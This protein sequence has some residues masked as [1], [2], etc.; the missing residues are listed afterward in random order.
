MTKIS[1][2]LI[3]GLG[4]PLPNTPIQIVSTGTNSAIVGSTA[5]TK[6]GLDG[7]YSF[8]V[9]VGS[10][11]VSIAFGSL[12][13]QY[14]GS[15]EISSGTPDASLDDILVIPASMQPAVLTKVL[16]ALVDAQNAAAEAAAEVMA[17]FANNPGLVS[18]ATLSTLQSVHPQSPNVLGVV[19]STGLYYQWDGS[20]WSLAGYQPSEAIVSAV[21][22]MSSSLSASISAAL[23]MAS[24]PLSQVG[25]VSTAGIKIADS[26]INFELSSAS[27]ANSNTY[28]KIKVVQNSSDLMSVLLLPGETYSDG[29]IIS[30]YVT[31]D[32][33]GVVPGVSIGT[34]VTRAQFGDHVLSDAYVNLYSYSVFD[35]AESIPPVYTQTAATLA[36]AGLSMH[37]SK[38]IQMTLVNSDIV[39]AGF[40][41]TEAGV[42]A[43]FLSNFPSLVVRYRSTG[44]QNISEHPVASVKAGEYEVVIPD[45]YTAELSMLGWVDPNLRMDDIQ[46]DV[47]SLADTVSVDAVNYPTS[48]VRGNHMDISGMYGGSRNIRL[49]RGW[50]L[51]NNKNMPGVIEYYIDGT[52]V[53]KITLPPSVCSIDGVSMMGKYK[54]VSTSDITGPSLVGST[55]TL[56]LLRTSVPEQVKTESTAA[57]DIGG[58]IDPRSH[59]AVGTYYSWDSVTV[60]TVMAG[61]SGGLAKYVH[62]ACLKSLISAAG[63]DYTDPAS[64]LD[65]VTS[66]LGLS[67][68]LWV[69]GVVSS[70]IPANL[71]DVKVGEGVLTVDAKYPTAGVFEVWESRPHAIPRIGGYSKY[72]G[73]MVNKYSKQWSGIPAESKVLFKPGEVFDDCDIVVSDSNGNIY[74]SQVCEDLHPNPRNK[75]SISRHRDGSLAAVSIL[76]NM[77]IPSDSSLD[78]ELKVMQSASRK[79]DV[80]NLV[81]VSNDEYTMSFGGYTYYFDRRYGWSLSKI[82]DPLGAT[83]AIE[84]RPAFSGFDPSSNAIVDNQSVT[85][86]SIRVTSSGPVFIEVESIGYNI[87]AY[88]IEQ[89]AIEYRTKTR[90]FKNGKVR[91]YSVISAVKD[92]PVSTLYGVHFRLNIL[93]GVKPFSVRHASALWDTA[94]GKASACV[95]RSNADIHR[96]GPAYGP[97]RPAIS[98]VISTGS[99]TRFYAGWKFANTSDASLVNYPVAKGW[100]WTQEMFIDLESTATSFSEVISPHY[101]IPV[102]FLSAWGNAYISRKV[103]LEKMKESVYG[104]MDWWYSGAASS[105]GGAT[106]ANGYTE[107]FYYKSLTYELMRHAVDDWLTLDKLASRVTTYMSRWNGYSGLGSKYLSG[108]LLL[109]FASRL[110]TPVLEWLYKL[111]VIEG[112]VAVQTDVKVGIKSFADAVKTVADANGGIPLDGSTS[113]AGN[114]NSNAAGLRILALAIYAGLDTSDGY[115]STFNAIEAV[116]TNTSTYTYIENN[117]TEGPN[118]SLPLTNYLHYQLYSANN[119]V[120][121]CRLLGKAPVIDMV[122]MCL[123]A[124]SALGGFKEVD[125][126]VSES[127]RGSFNTISFASLMLVTSQRAS[128]V[129]F[130]R[131]SMELHETERGSRPGYPKRLFGFDGTTSAGNTITDVSFDA[132]C[133]SET[134]LAVYTEEM[135]R[136]IA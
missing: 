115:L 15:M 54:A 21:N 64:V 43:Y 51:Y 136:S 67:I 81:K 23:S 6:T 25:V 98:S 19:S 48:K 105:S 71:Y 17:A 97:T 9:E 58:V 49:A 113:G 57:S 2:V 109:Q 123:Q 11:S 41:L 79:R 10:Y 121:A 66:K 30:P 117:I 65:Y 127:R 75:W 36:V 80:A 125:Y 122:N 73:D 96:D 63:Y 4:E 47:D 77:T 84:H 118:D 110:V 114:S 99:I 86:C 37:T 72:T 14:V 20:S 35:E 34:D 89:A 83:R 45:S 26:A 31:I 112:N 90:L 50:Q 53:D 87:A 44:Q 120:L 39:A 134:I 12:G 33:S 130:I 119:Y 16:Q 56:V 55:D 69:S 60:D 132:T 100:T 7:S 107:N 78:L 104:M 62:F 131:K 108:G 94:S 92:I 76:S 128:C 68:M 52:L 46:K 13:Y 129:N 116:L 1:G 32:L 111:A 126:C 124:S 93:D 38:F 106:T 27:R 24:A 101:N 82:V 40:Q 85:L 8:D 28:E 133:L 3:N 22:N 74:P 103:V 95:V 5:Y 42:K 88:G 18:A 59:F 29:H 61:S 70:T 135:L 102:A 91:L